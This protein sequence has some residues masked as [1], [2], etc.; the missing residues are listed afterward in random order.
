MHLNGLDFS[1]HVSRGKS[2]NH[3]GL[4]GTSLDSSDRHSSDTADLVNVLERKSEGLADGRL[5]WVDGVEGLEEGL[6]SLFAAFLGLFAP[7]LVPGH[8]LRL[9]D[10]VVTVPARD[11]DKGDS[12]GVVHLV[13]TDDQLFDSEGK[14]EK[15]VLAGLTVLSD[16][17]FKFTDTGSDNEDGAVSLRGTS[18][19]VLDK[20]TMAGRINDGDLELVGLELPEGDI[21]G[22]TTL[23]LGL[24]LVEDPGV[25]EGTLAHLLGLLLELF[26]GSLVDTAAF[27][28][29]M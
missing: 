25:L 14:G 20:V 3:T 18:N 19:H 5:R 1:G 28:D 22:D 10:H 11:G 2:D 9:F 27:V 7:T 6:T 26:N 23:S 24:E 8:V 21:D 12:L 13:D 15:S 29:E 16:T 4:D 17:G